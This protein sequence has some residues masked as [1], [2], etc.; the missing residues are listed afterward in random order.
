[1]K[2]KLICGWCQ[3]SFDRISLK[4]PTPKWC[5]ASCRQRGFDAKQ[6]GY[7]L[8]KKLNTEVVEA[9]RQQRVSPERFVR[10]AVEKALEVWE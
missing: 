8:T 6:R 5:S 9:S 3:R 2:E 1:M 4:G 7:R 10:Q